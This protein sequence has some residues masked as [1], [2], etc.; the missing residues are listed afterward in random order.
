[1]LPLVRRFLLDLTL[2]V[3]EP[4]NEGERLVRD[5]AVPALRELKELPAR[6]RPAANFRHTVCKA[7]FVA[8]VVVADQ[9]ALPVFQE[10]PAGLAMSIMA[11]NSNHVRGYFTG[12]LHAHLGN[13][14]ISIQLIRKA[15]ISIEVGRA[16]QQVGQSD[17]AGLPDQMASISTRDSV[18]NLIQSAETTPRADLYPLDLGYLSK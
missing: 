14:T 11:E 4:A 18:A 1:M 3:V 17:A 2:D 6:M 10:V 5:R 13:V 8:L 16:K 9:L 15:N 7:G 12:Y